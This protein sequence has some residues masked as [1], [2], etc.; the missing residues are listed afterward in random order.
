MK[1]L[2]ADHLAAIGFSLA[3]HAG[4][5]AYVLPEAAETRIAGGEEVS[6]MVIGDAFADAVMAGEEI[7]EVEAI[8]EA[9]P[10][11]PVTETAEAVEEVVQPVDTGSAVAVSQ[12]VQSS[13]PLRAIAA[14]ADP[15]SQ[16]AITEE[17]LK[18]VPEQPLPKPRPKVE[19]KP[20]QKKRVASPAAKPQK[21]IEKKPLQKAKPEPKKPVAKKK[22]GKKK[23]SGGKQNANARKSASGSKTAKQSSKAGNAAASNYPGKVYS[24]IARTRRK[25]AGGTGTARVSFSISSGGG[26]AGVR[27]ASSSGNSRVDSAAVAHVKRAAPFPKP[28]A[29]AQ[30]SFVIPIQFKR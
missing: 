10:V 19:K 5:A 14:L 28:P 3:V 22:A 26:L 11:E 21:Q 20:S 17:V 25:N 15:Q 27:L 13:Q 29:G 2:R 8:D 16:V 7:G 18:P 30:R 23:G 12:D 1:W 4:I 9:E 24:R 6:V